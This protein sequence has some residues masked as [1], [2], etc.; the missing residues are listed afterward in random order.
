MINKEAV[1]SKIDVLLKELSQ[2]FEHIAEKESVNPLEYE[3]FEVNAIYFA[4]HAKLLRKLLAVNEL[5][6]VVSNASKEVEDKE[7][8]TEKTVIEEEMGLFDNGLNPDNTSEQNNHND[9]EPE[10]Q[11]EIEETSINSE[12]LEDS[13]SGSEE[14]ES[15]YNSVE[16]GSGI[17]E[18]ELVVENDKIVGEEDEVVLEK[19]RFEDQPESR[20]ESEIEKAIQLESPMIT[21]TVVVEEREFSFKVETEQ[22]KEEKEIIEKISESIS[23]SQTYSAS[24]PESLN[25]RISA[26]RQSQS[27]ASGNNANSNLQRVGDIKS[28]INLN[29]KLL[30]IKDLF[31]GYSLAYSEAI[32]LLNRYE[33]F[34]DA[35]QFLQNNYAEKNNWASKKDTVEKLYAIL[36]KRYG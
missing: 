13:I 28:I 32:E 4:E 3:L 17:F 27:D 25:D 6:S 23:V 20:P 31:N 8:L 26:L 9:F 22:P 36:R 18:S 12:P 24:K 2:K 15:S 1:L 30:F 14:G 29:D 35:D 11:K 19:E 21:Q 33:S 10:V 5:E 34:T 16:K 7:V